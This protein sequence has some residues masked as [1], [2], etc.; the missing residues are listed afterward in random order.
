MGWHPRS[1]CLDLGRAFGRVPVAPRLGLVLGLVLAL[2]ACLAVPPAQA[3]RERA[4][5]YW[6]ARVVGDHVTAYQYEAVST[7]PEATLQGYISSRGTIRYDRASVEEVRML[8]DDKAEVRVALAYRFPLPGLKKAIEAEVWTDWVRID[9]KWYNLPRDGA[10][11][12]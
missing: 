12:Q 2:V 6:A 1:R 4:E 8:A 10:M 5:A 9:G 7:E 3:V 11:W